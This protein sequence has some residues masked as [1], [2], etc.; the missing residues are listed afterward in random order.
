M[1]YTKG[2]LKKSLF[3][4]TLTKQIY[5]MKNGSRNTKNQNRYKT[6]A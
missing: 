2:I 3:I 6:K 5:K 4:V 1:N